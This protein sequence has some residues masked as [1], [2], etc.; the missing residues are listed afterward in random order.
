[1]QGILTV[2]LTIINLL[3]IH[4][5]ALLILVNPT[6]EFHMLGKGYDNF[7][8]KILEIFSDNFISNITKEITN[9]S[10]NNIAMKC[11]SSG[12]LE[13]KNKEKSAIGQLTK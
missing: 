9:I 1:M 2:F 11:F 12:I 6:Y 13:Y 4:F 7:S 10:N 5:N 3:Q 8:L